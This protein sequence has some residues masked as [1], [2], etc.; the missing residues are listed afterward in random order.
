MSSDIDPIVGGI[1]YC[2]ILWACRNFADWARA[3]HWTVNYDRW[4]RASGLDDFTGSCRLHRA[5]VLGIQG[6]LAEARAMV[7][8]AI[9]QLKQD[10]PWA[11]GDALRVLG[12]IHLAAGDL[13]EA[14]L[15][16]HRAYSIGWD[17]QPGF[18][19]FQLEEAKLARQI[20]DSNGRYSAAAGP[21]CNG[22]A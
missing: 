10:A 11:I 15:A 19:L 12:D 20:R 21:P 3:S 9:E 17:P 16:Y 7:N 14:E 18:A 8:A 22:K 4:C 5:E 1:I 6:T 13:D 2:N